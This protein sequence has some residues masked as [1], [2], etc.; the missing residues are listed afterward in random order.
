[1]LDLIHA[2]IDD[3]SIIDQVAVAQAYELLPTICTTALQF[4]ERGEYKCGVQVC[5]FVFGIVQ[6]IEKSSV[7]EF[8]VSIWHYQRIIWGK[9]NVG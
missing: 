6:P 2:D 1:V 9:S 3:G 7:D 8:V 5:S 4:E